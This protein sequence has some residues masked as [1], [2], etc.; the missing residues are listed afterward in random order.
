MMLWRRVILIL[1]VV[2]AIWLYFFAPVQGVSSH[3]AGF[4]SGA[5]NWFNDPSLSAHPGRGFALPI[6]VVALALYLFLPGLKRPQT[7]IRYPAWRAFFIDLVSLILLVPGLT[8]PLFSIGRS[9]ASLGTGLLIG[10]AFWILVFPGL[11]LLRYAVWYASYRIDLTGE[12]IIVSNW[13]SQ[14]LLRFSEMSLVVPLILKAPGWLVAA[15][16][17]SAVLDR[18][19]HGSV[20]A[21]Q[22]LAA[23]EEKGLGLKFKDG[24]SVFIWIATAWGKRDLRNV[25]QLIGALRSASIPRQDEP[26]IIKSVSQ[27]LGETAAGGKQSI[28]RLFSAFWVLLAEAVFFTLSFF[29]VGGSV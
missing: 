24:S 27:P 20:A 26:R 16:S 5:A 23:N 8:F 9:L 15:S 25:D 13:K 12:G 19:R 1:G 7:A 28:D 4:G 14:T 18:G 10:L 11:K 17:A 22:A 21:S 29:A 6:L 2:M 3:D